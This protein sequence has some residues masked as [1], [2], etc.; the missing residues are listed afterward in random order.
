LHRGVVAFRVEVINL[1][2]RG[3]GVVVAGISG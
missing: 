1:A 3:W 2:L